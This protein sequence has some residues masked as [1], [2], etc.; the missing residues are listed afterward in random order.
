MRIFIKKAFSLIEIMIVVVIISILVTTMMANYFGILNKVKEKQ[1]ISDL[2]VLK[3]GII[4]F[5]NQYGY[6]P[7]N[8]LK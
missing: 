4:Q 3:K 8:L 5:K 7:E 6:W 2:N 1:L